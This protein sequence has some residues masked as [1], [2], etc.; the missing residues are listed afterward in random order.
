MASFNRLMSDA[1]VNA[2]VKG[3]KMFLARKEVNKQ[4]I[5][6]TFS[7]FPF[8]LFYFCYTD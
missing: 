5:C 4:V 6:S 2:D 1:V 8:E 3:V 7:F